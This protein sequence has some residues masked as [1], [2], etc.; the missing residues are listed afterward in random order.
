MVPVAGGE[1]EDEYT[2]LLVGAGP[3]NL[4]PWVKYPLPSL[5]L[6]QAFAKLS[7]PKVFLYFYEL[8]HFFS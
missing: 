8:Y 7:C 3:R 5:D 6:R 2:V 4:Y 1:R